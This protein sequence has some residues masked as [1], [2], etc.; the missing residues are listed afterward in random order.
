MSLVIDLTSDDESDLEVVESVSPIDITRKTSTQLDLLSDSIDLAGETSTLPDL[1]PNS[2][3]LTSE[4][5]TLP[6]L[7]PDSELAS[8]LENAMEISAHKWKE[9]FLECVRSP[10]LGAPL[11]YF[12]RE[13]SE[14]NPG[15]F[16]HG[17]GKIGLP[18]ST[19]D[20]EAIIG[21]CNKNATNDDMASK[22]TAIDD[23]VNDVTVDTTFTGT[24]NKN[25]WELLPDEFL[26]RN[27]DWE[28]TISMAINQAIQGLS[29]LTLK[30]NIRAVLQKLV[31]FEKGQSLTYP[32]RLVNLIH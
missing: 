17:A 1:L 30:N 13:I 10:R 8:P 26:I 4:T 24:D 14:T 11:G 23:A 7:L 5:S 3:D 20:A 9:E 16:I 22:G 29:I 18:L 15:L 21:I 19:R 32:P 6:D 28:N 25:V 2:I 27:P 31:L 12:K